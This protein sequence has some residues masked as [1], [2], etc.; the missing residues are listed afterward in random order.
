MINECIGSA[1]SRINAIVNPACIVYPSRIQSD[2]RSR[3]ENLVSRIYLRK[4]LQLVNKL[5]TIPEN[6][7][8]WKKRG[9][10]RERKRERVRAFVRH[11]DIRSPN[12]REN[13][14]SKISD[15]IRGSRKKNRVGFLLCLATTRPRI[16]SFVRSIVVS[17][18]YFWTILYFPSAFSRKG[19]GEPT[20]RRDGI[21]FLG[22]LWFLIW[23][24]GLKFCRVLDLAIRC[25]SSW[26]C[27][28]KYRSVDAQL[29]ILVW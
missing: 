21:P 2:F 22:S 18:D 29:L 15:E 1:F 25:D 4:G 13:G 19:N 11:Y 17:K 7:G 14:I 24:I 9:R 28:I 20:E 8:S 16:S 6:R 5:P 12:S 26:R 10:E 3:K 23:N 27:I